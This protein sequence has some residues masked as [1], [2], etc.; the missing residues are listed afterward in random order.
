MLELMRRQAGNWIIKIILGLIALAFALS[1]GLSPNFGSNPGVAMKVND[2][3]IMEDAVS[4]L[5]GRMTEQAR[6]QFGDNFDKLA[7]MLNLRQ[8]ALYSL[9][10]RLLLAQAA[11]RMG[12]GV[13]NRELASSIQDMAAFQVEGKF[14]MRLYQ[15]RLAANRLTEERFEN[16][17]RADLLQ[18][19]IAAMVGGSGQVTPL[20]VDQALQEALS[21]A[22]AVYLLVKPEDLLDSVKVGEDEIAEHY[23]SHKG[24]YMNPATLRVDYVALPVSAFRDKADVAE[25]EIIDA[26]EMDWRQYSRP[27]EVRARHILIELA[28]E[29]DEAQKAKAKAQALALLEKARAGEDFA[30]MAK[31]YSKGPSADKGGDLGYFQRGQMVGPFDELV[32]K[33]TPGQIEVVE[34]EFGWHV[35]KLEDKKKARIVPLEEARGEIKA[36]LAEQQAK[37]LAMQAAEGLF[38]AL[39]AGQPLEAAAKERKLVVEQ[40]PAVTADQPVPGL[41]GLKDLFAAAQGLEAGQPLRPMTFDGGAVVAVI[42]QRTAPQPKPLDKVREQVEMAVRSEKANQLAQVQAK[43]I[44]AKLNAAKDPAAALSKLGGKPTGPLTSS[45]PIEG[46]PGSEQLQQAIHALA[47]D[48]TVLAQPVPVAGGFAVAV[49]TKRQPPEP[50]AMDQMREGMTQQLRRTMQNQTYQRFLADLRNNAD[51]LAPQQTSGGGWK[52]PGC[53]RGVDLEWVRPAI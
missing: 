13:S 52:I 19:K 12:L 9:M 29:A 50:G 20:Q 7:P 22:D 41:T 39:A 18:G 37:D 49:V 5:Y 53:D 21:R 47:Q 46:L 42:R 3:P 4:E 36:R 33:M 24:L 6:Q 43:E 32:F 15:Q 30:K 27:E 1:F 48:K 25:D 8:Q 23:E 16:S 38:D 34:T 45:E 2:Q 11:Q 14:D 17:V 35:V 44:I 10:D 28:P 26:Y 51:I 40:P 31:E